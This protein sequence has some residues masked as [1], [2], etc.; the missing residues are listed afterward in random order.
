[1][2][3]NS[4]QIKIVSIIILVLFISVSAS[5]ILSLRNQKENLLSATQRTLSVNTQMLNT[6]IR[7]IMLSGEAPIAR[8]TMNSLSMIQEFE[9]VAIYRTDGTAAFN[10]YSTIDYVNNYQDRVMFE[11]TERNIKTMID[12]PSFEKVLR[13]STPLQVELLDSREME[14]YFPILNFG[15]CRTCHGGTGFIRGV[16]H[17]RVSLEGI[18][19]QIGQARRNLTIFFVISGVVI[20]LILILMMKRIIINPIFTIGETVKSVETGFSK[21][22]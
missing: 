20:A 2:K 4:I 6:V 17:F 9:E 12:N 1:M 18:Y 19:R 13:T 7:N 8:N 16:A 11:R 14:Y 21:R 5:L 10:D 15:E 22:V 3:L